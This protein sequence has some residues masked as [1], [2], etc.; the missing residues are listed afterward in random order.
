[1]V[2]PELDSCSGGG[3]LD[4]FPELCGEDADVLIVDRVEPVR[5]EEFVRC[6]SENVLGGRSCI[7]NLSRRVDYENRVRRLLD[8]GLE[9]FA[10]ELHTLFE[11][12]VCDRLLDSIG[13]DRI[14]VGPRLFLQIIGDTQ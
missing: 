5:A 12:G 7:E 6:P 8:E 14:L 2:I 9:S 10:S 11:T 4:Q 3:I 13:Q 1:M